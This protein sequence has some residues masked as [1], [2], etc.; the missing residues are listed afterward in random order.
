MKINADEIRSVVEQV[1]RMLQ[2]ETTVSPAI[3][4]ALEMLLLI[5]PLLLNRIGLNSSN[6]STSPSKDQ[7]RKKKPSN[8]SGNRSYCKLCDAA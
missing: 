2:E 1:R 4:A 8:G 5:V 7:N 3:R 6:S